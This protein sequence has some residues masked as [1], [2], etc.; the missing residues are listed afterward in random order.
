MKIRRTIPVVTILIFCLVIFSGCAKK[1]TEEKLLPKKQVSIE[2]V[3][4]QTTV[5]DILTLSGSVVPKQYSKIHSLVP[6]TVEY[7]A[8]VGS[9]VVSGQPLFKIA[10]AN[11][12]SAFFNAQRN[13]EQTK[14]ITQQR[15]VQ[16]RLAV[17]NA[18]VSAE[19]AK[20]NL[21]ITKQQADQQTL[22]TQNS[23]RVTYATAYNAAN[24]VLVALNRGSITSTNGLKFIYDSILTSNTQI[25]TDAGS[26]LNVAVG[27]FRSVPATTSLGVLA[28]DLKQLY[29]VLVETKKLT[30]LTVLTLQSAIANAGFP[31]AEIDA[32]KLLVAGYQTQINTYTEAI[33]QAQNAIENIRLGNELSISRAQSQL[34]TA[35]TQLSNAEIGLKSAEDGAALEVSI[36]EG[37]YNAASY[38]YGNLSLASPFS[39]TVLSHAVNAGEQVRVGQEVLE[40]GNTSIAEVRVD[41]GASYAAA[42]KVGD[43]AL[44]NGEIRA[45]ISEIEPTGDIVS[46]N[47]GVTVQADNSTGALPA[48][49]LV[50]VRFSLSFPVDNALVIPIRAAQIDEDATTVLV[51]E[52]GKATLRTVRLGATYGAR[53]AVLEGL[54]EGDAV[55]LPNGIFVSPGDEIEVDE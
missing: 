46:G 54:I 55:I 39:G 23:A 33:N 8:P 3:Q 31:Q 10:D 42:L 18:R 4:K 5:S 43:E 36:A 9:S 51:L 40:V 29:G 32:A 20:S 21:A 50:D 47:V 49:A 6:G 35:E 12:E 17:D 15:V 7:L 19:L 28:D 52:N 13:F 48:G 27:V 26:Q 44:L 34:D 53:V 11:I 30:D 24:Q 2:R 37:G 38:Q 45:R 25:Q 41:V 22:A 14:I 16:A 1:K